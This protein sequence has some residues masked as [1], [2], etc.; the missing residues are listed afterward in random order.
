MQKES[1]GPEWI[2]GR[3]YSLKKL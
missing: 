2:E 3:L 1:P